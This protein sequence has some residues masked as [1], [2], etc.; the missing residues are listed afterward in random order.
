[1]NHDSEKRCQCKE[2]GERNQRRFA[3]LALV[4]IASTIWFVIRS[5]TK[6]SRILY[7]CQ[8]AALANIYLFKAA[9][10][11][12]LPSLASLKISTGRLK[13]LIILVILSVGGFIMTTDQTQIRLDPLQVDSTIERVPIVLSPQTAT[14]LD[15]ASNLFY[16]QNVT[17]IEGNMDTAVIALIDLMASEG[18]HFYN[19]TATPDGLIKSDDIIIIKI[20]SQWDR[21]GGTN[22]DLIKSVINAIIAHPDGFTG[23]VVI[24]DNGQGLGSMDY[25]N[26]NSYYKNQTT[27]DVA[28][29]F[30]PEWDV[31]TILWDDLHYSTV[32]D[33][34]DDDFTDG[35]V[36]STVWNEETQ[37]YT[38]YPKFRSPA[39]GAY[40]SF[41]QGVWHNDT[42]FDFNGLK[43]INMPVLK[44]H[45]L[46]GVTACVKH[47]MG[48]PQGHIVESVSPSV[49]HEHYSVRR[50]GMGTMIAE[51]RAPDLNILDMV[52]IN[53]NP[54][55]SSIDRGPWSIYSAASATDI[56]G[57][58]IDP[59]ALD[60]W[61]AKHVLVPTAQYLNYASYSSLDPDYEPISEHINYPFV[62]QEESFHNYLERSMNI[63]KDAGFQVTMDESDMNVF[64]DTM[65]DAGP[66]TPTTPNI[67]DPIN[68]VPILIGGA[69]L[70]LIAILAVFAKRRVPKEN[71]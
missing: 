29:F 31:S 47:Y 15:N 20:N 55:E 70:V 22:T 66:I 28:D 63:L 60:Y 36:R 42:G 16:V 32:D 38:S 34:D 2:K 56:I 64:V 59:V 4:A 7:P 11:V 71:P 58:S 44:S 14:S 54:L 27:Q 65:T 68:Y 48:V 26:P 46:L 62:Q 6:P 61:S 3:T 69:G 39:T 45:E 13:T 1:M 67:P 40:I 33:Y 35:Y 43:I 17:G 19:T 24:A 23:E 49:P 50:G 18:I 37:L 8:Q 53:A 41:K 25:S 57:A 21:R 9:I 5:G 52:W 30:A 10:S 51:T 12:S